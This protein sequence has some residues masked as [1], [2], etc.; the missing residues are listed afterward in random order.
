MD[1]RK[2]AGCNVYACSISRAYERDNKTKLEKIVSEIDKK[3]EDAVVKAYYMVPT[4]RASNDWN[5]ELVEAS[6]L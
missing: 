4:D 6:L 2:K 3:F 1:D 5:P